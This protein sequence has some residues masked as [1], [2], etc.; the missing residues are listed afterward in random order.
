M[1]E[2]KARDREWFKEKLAYG[3]NVA[4]SPRSIGTGAFQPLRVSNPHVSTPRNSRKGL[5]I[6]RN[7]DGSEVYG[8]YSRA[9]A[10]Q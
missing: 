5:A 6:R 7:E 8:G 1:Q 2:Q 10:R 9:Q 3:M 4:L